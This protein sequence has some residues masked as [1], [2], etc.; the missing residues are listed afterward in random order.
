[1]NRRLRQP[2]KHLQRTREVK[3]RQI[4]KDDKAD[5]EKR[6][7]LSLSFLGIVIVQPGADA[8]YLN[9]CPHQLGEFGSTQ[10]TVDRMMRGL[11]LRRQIAVDNQLIVNG[12]VMAVWVKIISK[13]NVEGNVVAAVRKISPPPDNR[14]RPDSGVFVADFVQDI[15][16]PKWRTQRH[17]VADFKVRIV[18]AERAQAA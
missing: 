9:E 4:R 13:M 12:H 8:T 16:H 14:G 5:I 7:T 15:R 18:L 10:I 17:K 1:M 6:H 2:R 11:S 3:L